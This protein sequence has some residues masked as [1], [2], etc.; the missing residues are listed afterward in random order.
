V[1]IFL[2]RLVALTILVI[3]LVLTLVFTQD[4]E[5]PMRKNEMGSK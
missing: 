5:L 3:G 2:P 1:E 4:R